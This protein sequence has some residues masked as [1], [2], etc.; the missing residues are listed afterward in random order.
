[1][2]SILTDGRLPLGGDVPRRW[3]R[4]DH[5]GVKAGTLAVGVY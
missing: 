4:L 1:M 2:M 3:L 5:D